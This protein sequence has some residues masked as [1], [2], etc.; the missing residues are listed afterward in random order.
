[1]IL[2]MLTPRST[3]LLAPPHVQAMDLYTIY[4]SPGHPMRLPPA[5]QVSKNQGGVDMGKPIPVLRPPP[6]P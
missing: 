2:C 3:P 6:Y 4:A 5:Y 1:M